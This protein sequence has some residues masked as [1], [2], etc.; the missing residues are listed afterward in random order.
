MIQ[1]QKRARQA[2]L[3]R[4]L[5][6]LVVYLLFMTGVFALLADVLPSP[7][8][9]AWWMAFYIGIVVG[10]YLVLVGVIEIIR[11]KRK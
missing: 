2:F 10:L 5:V 7:I 11:K 9:Q 4:L 8:S 1:H 3:K 6:E